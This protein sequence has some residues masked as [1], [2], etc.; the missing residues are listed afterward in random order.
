[1]P[2]PTNPLPVPGLPGRDH[3]AAAAT[4]CRAPRRRA[5]PPTGASN[6]AGDAFAIDLPAAGGQVLTV[7]GDGTI[8]M[9]DRGAAGERGRWAFVARGGCPEYPEIALD[10]SGAPS[11]GGSPWGEVRGLV[12]GHM[13]MMA[14]EFLGGRIHCGRPWH[15]YGVTY[16]M[17]DCPDHYPNGA[18]RGGRERALLRRPR[19]HATTRSAGRRSRTG[20]RTRR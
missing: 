13:H 14:F 9:R 16:A 19:A 7:A 12:D 17:V 5:R 18:G 20:R 2:T 15:P 10:V 8:I 3:D 4:A 1:M 6:G 11:V